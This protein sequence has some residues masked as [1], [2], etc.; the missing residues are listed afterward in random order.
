MLIAVM[1]LAVGFVAYWFLTRNTVPP[2]Q[3]MSEEQL[4]AEGMSRT[5]IRAE[6]RKQRQELRSH[7]HAQAHSARAAQQVARLAFSLLKKAAK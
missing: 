5:Q 2:P 3:V 1:V 7:T 6:L 4:A